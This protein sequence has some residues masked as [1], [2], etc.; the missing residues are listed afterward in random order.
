VI[1]KFVTTKFEVPVFVIVISVTA[2]SMP[3]TVLLNA[4]ELGLMV[5]VCAAAVSEVKI[6]I[7]QHSVK[8]TGIDLKRGPDFIVGAKLI[9]RKLVEE[10]SPKRGASLILGQQCARIGHASLGL[11]RH[12]EYSMGQTN[13]SDC[14]GECSQSTPPPTVV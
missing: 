14:C 6:A 10:K 4:I 12:L 1:E 9:T 13:L 3:T 11:Q 8:K 2:V 7:A 5:N